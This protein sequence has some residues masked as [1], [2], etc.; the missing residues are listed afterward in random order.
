[1]TFVGATPYII[2][3]HLVDISYW[4]LNFVP[5]ASDWNSRHQLV[6]GLGLSLLICGVIGDLDSRFKRQSLRV[7]FGLCVVW[8]LTYMHGYYLDSIKQ[9]EIISAIR[10]SNDFNDSKIIMVNDLADRFNARG[11]GI[12]SYEFDGMFDF[13]KSASDVKTITGYSYVKCN[14]EFI[15][16]TLMTITA[17][18][19]RLE[20]TITGKVGIEISVES[21]RPCG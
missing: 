6:L 8:N 3:G 18:N 16:D 7:L 11:R 2:G 15:P 9:N 13:A 14:D 17:R 1:M 21:I 12:R 5:G 10:Q 4:M 19:G 20:S